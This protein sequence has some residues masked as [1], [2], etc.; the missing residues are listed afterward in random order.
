MIL[1]GI[2]SSIVYFQLSESS[3]PKNSN[4]SY[5]APKSTD[6]LALLAGAILIT[7]KDPTVKF[8]G[9]TI[10]GIHIQQFLHHKKE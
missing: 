7:K 8:I 1:L 3:I 10:A 9:A 5:L 2:A 4:C 6:Y